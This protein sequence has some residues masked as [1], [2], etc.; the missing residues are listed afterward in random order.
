MINEIRIGVYVCHCGLNIAG[1]IDIDKLVEEASRLDDVAV[2][3]AN[4]YCCSEPGQMEIQKDI[5]E[6]SLNRVVVTAGSPRLHEVTFKRAVAA[7]GLN[8]YLL[9]MVNIREHCSWVHHGDPEKARAK[10]WD[11]LKMGIAKA[12]RLSP[13][14]DRTSPV[15]KRALVLG[16]GVAGLKAS[17]VIADSGF[18]VD[19]VEKGPVLGGAAVR[20]SRVSPAFETGVC[21]LTPMV[22]RVAR[23]PRINKLVNSEI[24]S[25]EG[26]VGA[27]EVGVRKR[28]TF[29]NEN[30]DR[31]GKCLSACNVEVPDGH[32]QG[33]AQRKAV[34]LPFDGCY[35]DRFVI[36][37]DSCTRCGDCVSACPADAIDLTMAD[38]RI[39]LSIG[40]VIV[41]TGFSSFKPET[42][43]LYSYSRFDN[44]VTSSQL[45][46]MLDPHGPT[47]GRIL[48]ISDGKAPRRIAFIQ[49]VGSRNEETHP[50]CSKICCQITLKQARQITDSFPEIDIAVYYK[51]IRANRK[52]YEEIYAEIRKKGVLFVRGE[53]VSVDENQDR[54]LVVRAN[55]ELFGREVAD[56]VDLVVLATGMEPCEKKDEIHKI[57][58]VPYSADGFFLE[59]HPK[60]RPI[61]T[62]L[63]GIFLAGSCHGPKDISE[64]LSHASGAAAKALGMFSKDY[65]SLDAYVAVVDE[66]KCNGCGICAGLCPYR[67]IRIV[68]EKKEKKA[69]VVLA[70]CK[71]CGVCAGECPENAVTVQGFTHD[72]LT[73]QIDAALE[74][75]PA[76]KIVAF[77]CNWCSYAGADCAGVSR[78]QYPSNVRIVRTLCSGRV[79]REMIMRAFENGAGMVLVSGCHPPGDCHYISGNLVAERRI[80]RLKKKLAKEGFDTNRLRL[81]WISATEG[82]VFTQ[83]INEM[84][85]YLEKEMLK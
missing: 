43:D 49:C 56:E 47:Q 59:S 4:L 57:L 66:E 8:P 31:C 52:G 41:A 38:E 5:R 28:P 54:S 34:Y 15:K 18:E 7:A 73:S 74:E 29:V 44:V 46:R 78:M 53:I 79:S 19:L 13:L 55:A 83:T 68:G 61:E 1:V 77:C 10:A 48:R 70:A 84:N 72:Q 11:L 71:G 63:D 81:Q 82:A 42:H 27:F 9:E 39:K 24:E 21:L 80:R 51:D 40:A 76:E 75:N 3:R 16:G 69:Q 45:E 58:T 67:A 25:I 12:R 36:D 23:H 17:L 65:L 20:L 62:S 35:P 32:Q 22:T 2:A 26:Y 14:T 30:C 85:D 50:Y 64:T 37:S 60:L 6:L 33:L